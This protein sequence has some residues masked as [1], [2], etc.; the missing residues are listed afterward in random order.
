MALDTVIVGYGHAARSFH[1]AALP[2][3]VAHGYATGTVTLVDPAATDPPPGVPLLHRLPPADPGRD[4]VVH[5]CTPPEHHAGV[6]IGASVLGYRRFVVEKPMATNAADAK[7]MVALCE[8]DGADLLMVANWTASA[9]TD[10]LVALLRSRGVPLRAITLRQ[11][12]PRL[13]RTM[14]AAW[15]VSPFDV[16]MP[17]LVA[18]LFTLVDGPCEL[19]G[20]TRADLRVDGT[21]YPDMAAAGLTA[22]TAEG[23]PVTLWSDLA[24]PWR[25]RVTRLS[26][27][28]GYE[29]AAY[30]PCDST[31]RYAQLVIRPGRGAPVRHRFVHDDTVRRFLRGAYAHFLGRGPAPRSDVYFG[32]RVTQLLDAA[33]RISV[34][35]PYR[36]AESR[37]AG[38]ATDPDR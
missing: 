6:V 15:P 36:P 33:K 22:R 24:A 32:A 34:T 23:V 35:V 11:A 30:H 31:D 7:E 4:S 20:A 3:L 26:W 14:R 27:T 37:E 9:L 8:R 2:D 5:V 21:R 19:T 10:E 29:V 18:L 28:D 38:S 13:E 1:V 17:H 25:E 16:E 12:K